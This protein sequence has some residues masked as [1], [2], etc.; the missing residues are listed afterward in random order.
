MAET[1]VPDEGSSRRQRKAR[2]IYDPAPISDRAFSAALA[3]GMEPSEVTAEN[4]RNALKAVIAQREAVRKAEAE[5]AAEENARRVAIE[6]ATP[7]PLPFSLPPRERSPEETLLL[8]Y[9][10]STGSRGD[11][12]TRARERRQARWANEPELLLP[13]PKGSVV[14][15]C[16]EFSG[17]GGFEHGLEA[18][19][20]EAGLHFRLIEASELEDTQVGKHATAVLQ[21]RFP[22]CVVLGPV[23]RLRCPYC[24]S[25]DMVICT[26]ICTEHSGLNAHGDPDKTDDLIG[27]VRAR[28]ELAPQL[29]VIALENVP[30]FL[31]TL[32]SQEQSSYTTWV[33]ALEAL[34]FREHAYVVMPTGVAGDLHWRNRLLSVH[35][36]GHGFHPAAALLRLLDAQKKPPSIIRGRTAESEV[37]CFTTGT[38]QT[39]YALKGKLGAVWG[40]LPAYSSNLNVGLFFR[41]RFY[42]LSAW[43]AA[44]ASGLPEGYQDVSSSK[45]GRA[46]PTGS[47]MRASETLKA[48]GLANMVSPLQAREMGH[49][50]AAEWQ[51][52]RTTAQLESL[53]SMTTLPGSYGGQVPTSFPRAAS[54]DLSQPATLCYNSVA[55]GTWHSIELQYWKPILPAKTLDDLCEEA[56]NKGE[57][58]LLRS[59]TDLQRVVD[60]TTLGDYPRHCA[61]QQ[62][63]QVLRESEQIQS[64]RDERKLEAERRRAVRLGLAWQL[65]ATVADVL[66]QNAD[67]RAHLHERMSQASWVSCDTCGKWRR[68]FREP[69]AGK[70]WACAQNP[71]AAYAS[72]ASAQELSDDEIDRLLGLAGAAPQGDS[73]RGSSSIG[74]TE[75]DTVT[76]CLRGAS[77]PPNETPSSFWVACDRCSKWR[78]LIAEPDSELK[79]QAWFCELNPDRRR[80]ACDVGEEEWDE[81]ATWE[82]ESLSSSKRTRKRCRGKACDD[83]NTS[84]IATVQAAFD[85]G[86]RTGLPLAWGI[87]LPCREALLPAREV[88]K[89]VHVSSQFEGVLVKAI[90]KHHVYS[91]ARPG[92][93]H[94][95]YVK[96]SLSDGQILPFFVPSEPLLGTE[97]LADYLDCVKGQPLIKYVPQRWSAVHRCV[98]P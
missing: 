24:D 55:K 18:G 79:G 1:V 35:T 34:G 72:C 93:L 95:V 48:T 29:E 64:V 47:E 7:R 89:Q 94:N 81:T 53:V 49:A 58:R 2:V 57:L 38:G 13:M 98:P 26:P 40:H 78:R 90:L 70:E 36:R 63:R 52:P 30:N 75:L 71:D 27:S 41:G 88:D 91:G 3:S 10:P 97:V 14:D 77:Q 86:R 31:S 82:E 87:P 9:N 6:A 60:D 85:Q 61:A 20:G 96:L 62:H 11:A 56:L 54:L 51:A 59:L 67:L 21:K 50:I 16:S 43:L 17:I 12:H 5:R 92:S 42:K 66:K 37:F 8:T 32:D 15:V 84:F 33:E 39:R 73:E 83:A 74:P 22:D 80:N 45:K 44:Q 28:L 25:A 4:A 23:S 69:T 46:A 19:F 68:L 65:K 76:L